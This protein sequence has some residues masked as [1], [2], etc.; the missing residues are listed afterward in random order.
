VLRMYR[1]R[2]PRLRTRGNR[3]T[4]ETGEQFST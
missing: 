4:G 2:R 3:Q 1:V